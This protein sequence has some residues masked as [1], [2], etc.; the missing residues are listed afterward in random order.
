MKFSKSAPAPSFSCLYVLYFI[1]LF[2]TCFIDLALV[3]LL[4]PARKEMWLYKGHGF[5]ARL[6]YPRETK[7]DKDV[8]SISTPEIYQIFPVCHQ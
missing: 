4:A 2:C 6:D 7:R 5:K 8:T 3:F 1:N